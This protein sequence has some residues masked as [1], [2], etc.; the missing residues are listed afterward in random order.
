MTESLNFLAG[1]LMFAVLG[2]AAYFMI[3]WFIRQ[4]DRSS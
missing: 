1:P 3:D 2:L 4:S